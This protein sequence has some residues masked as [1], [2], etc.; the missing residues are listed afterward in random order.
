MTYSNGSSFTT[1]EGTEREAPI[2]RIFAAIS[3]R[4]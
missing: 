1:A 2:W 4:F 3:E